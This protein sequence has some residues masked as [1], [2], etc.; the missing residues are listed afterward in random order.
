M[1]VTLLKKRADRFEKYPSIAS[2]KLKKEVTDIKNTTNRRNSKLKT[3]ISGELGD[4]RNYPEYRTEM[5]RWKYEK[6]IQHIS[7]KNFILKE[8]R[9]IFGEMMT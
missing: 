6:E 7:N 8:E 3:K 5:K 2:Q 9:A 1:Q 4:G